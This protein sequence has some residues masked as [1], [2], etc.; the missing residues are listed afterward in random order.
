MFDVSFAPISGLGG[1]VGSPDA[2]C[3]SRSK[4][5]LSGF[6]NSG[7]ELSIKLTLAKFN[8]S[9]ADPQLTAMLRLNFLHATPCL[10]QANGR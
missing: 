4:L 9:T 6:C 8:V 1:E 2:L 5:E 10:Q 3:G 7:P